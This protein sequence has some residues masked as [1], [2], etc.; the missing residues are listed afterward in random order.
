MSNEPQGRVVLESGAGG[1]VVQAVHVFL[2]K[3][4]YRPVIQRQVGKSPE[5]LL[6]DQNGQPCPL[7]SGHARQLN[8]QSG[9]WHAK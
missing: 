6:Y 4:G 5:F 3:L 2:E 1:A 7:D 9:V 8:E